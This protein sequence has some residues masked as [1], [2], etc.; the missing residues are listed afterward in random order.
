MTASTI[1][2]NVNLAKYM[3]DAETRQLKYVIHIPKLETCML[4][5]SF[6]SD[7]DSAEVLGI[8][9][10]VGACWTRFGAV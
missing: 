6:I 8:L 9:L 1:A 2:P 5:S 10:T 7:G 4:G 3:L